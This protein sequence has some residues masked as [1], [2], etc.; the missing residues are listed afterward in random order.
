MSILLVIDDDVTVLEVFRRLFERSDLTVL[1]AASAEEGINHVTRAEPD[2]IVLDVMLPDESGL[3]TFGRIHRFD[4]RV[5]IIVISASSD[6][7][8]VIEAM[9]LGAFDY[10]TKPLNFPR[11]RELVDKALQI[12]RLMHVPVA[13]KGN[14]SSGESDVLVGTCPQMQEVYKAIGRVAG[15]NATVLIRGDSGTGKELI[16]RAIYQ[17][18]ARKEGK[19]LA[20]NCAAIPETLLESE[21]FG[22]EKGAFTGAEARRIGMF[23]QCSG[24]TLFLDE[25]GDMTPLS[26]SKVLRV[27]QEQKFERVGG[28]ETIQT[29]VRIITATNRNLEQMVAGGIFRADLY[30]RLNGFTIN[31]PPLRERA[32]DILVLVRH[33]LAYYSRELGKTVNEVSPEAQAILQ[34]Y[35]WPGNIRQLQSVIRQ[36]ILHGTGRVLLPDFLPPEVRE[37]TST[38][39]AASPAD[40]GGLSLDTFITDELRDHTTTLYADAVAMLERMLLTRV[41]A[42]TS[43]NRSQAAK[44]LGIARGSLRSKI[45]QLHI[46][47]DPVISIDSDSEEEEN[48]RQLEAVG[49]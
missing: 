20:I 13:L 49:E 4:S 7:D 22:H 41:L 16:A 44:I 8:T 46:T 11:V 37:E 28:R 39:R 19:F 27:L 36:A 24:G 29:D 10:L 42:H 34:R 6:S 12:R 32:E 26:Q 9:R 23:E 45:R 40:S 33:F 38:A 30:Y 35:S 21:L 2:A 17:H 47:I 18:S 43:G 31:L 1:T 14:D 25:I 48:D 3:E 15:Q 5:P